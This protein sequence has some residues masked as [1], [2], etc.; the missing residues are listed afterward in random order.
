MNADYAEVI[1][2]NGTI[3]DKNLFVYCENNPVM[4]ADADGEFW[5]IVAGAAIGAVVGGLSSI[6]SQANCRRGYQLDG[7]SHIGGIWCCQRRN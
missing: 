6:I 2:D 7:G 3:T 5:H 4:R 1:S